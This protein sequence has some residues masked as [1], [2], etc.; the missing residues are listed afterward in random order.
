MNHEKLMRALYEYIHGKIGDA[1]ISD[2]DINN[3]IDEFMAK[4]NAEEDFGMEPPSDLTPENAETVDD[5]IELADITPYMEDAREYLEKAREL[6]PKNLDVLGRMIFLEEKN[7]FEYI[8]DIERALEIGRQDLKDRG[9]YDKY[10]GN[11]WLAPETRPFMFLYAHY[12]H[13]LCDCQMI[14]KAIAAAEDMLKLNPSD[15]LTISHNLIALYVYREDEVKALELMEKFPYESDSSWFQLPLALLY[16]REGKTKEAEKAIDLLV[17]K[18]PDFSDFVKDPMGTAEETIQNE[19]D[20]YE[21]YEASELIHTCADNVF[22][23][24]PGE[25]FFLWMQKYLGIE[26]EG[27]IVERGKLN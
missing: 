22:L 13:I 25:R 12:V 24:F 10:M 3:L 7:D 4:Y 21:P 14:K 17:K 8:P 5:W 15:N 19:D 27:N 9:L 2:E 6:D 11:F 16:F 26:D 1:D 20:D 18:Y 23:W